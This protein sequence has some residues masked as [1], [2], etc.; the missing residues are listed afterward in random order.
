MANDVPGI[1]GKLTKFGVSTDGTD[2]KPMCIFGD[3]TVDFGNEVL[4]K[5]YCI[6]SKEPYI[7]LGNNEFADITYQ[8]AWDEDSAVA[9]GVDIIEKAKSASTLEGSTIYVQVEINNSQG[10]SLKGT[11]FEYKAVVGGYKVLAVEDGVVKS[12]FTMAQTT[13]PTK[14]PSETP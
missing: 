8:S 3:L 10:A 6:S 11:L 5:E 13:I 1:S 2:Y 7:S 4:N 9:E 14:T 12:E